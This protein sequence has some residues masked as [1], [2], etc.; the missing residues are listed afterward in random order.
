M[1]VAGPN[2]P[3]QVQF[4]LPSRDAVEEFQSLGLSMDHGVTD[5]AD[6]GALVSAWV[7][8]EELAAVRARGFDPV[9]TIADKNLIDH[10]R[11][12]RNATLEAQ[13]SAERALR[14][15][16]AG[17]RGASA[18]AGT[19][20][21]QRAEFY[22]NNVGR[23]LSIEAVA[24]SYVT[25]TSGGCTTQPIVAEWYDAAGNRIG[26]GNLIV[27]A[28]PQ[29]NPDYYQFHYQIFRIGNKGDGG[30]VP[31]S[32]KVAAPNGDVD[33][34]ATRE[35]IAE[36]PPKPPA[37]FLSGFVTHYNDSQEAYKKMRDLA[38]EFPNIAEAIN[39]PEKTL[40]YQRKAQTMLGYN[41]AAPYVTFDANN[42][43]VAGANPQ[44]AANQARTV[45]LTS[46]AH[47]HLGGNDLNAQLVNPGAPNAALSISLNGNA[48]R[49][50]LATDSGGAI[51]STAAQVVA[52]L[53]AHPQ[54]SA[55][56]TASIYRTSPANGVVVAGPVSPLSDLLR[57][58]ATFPRGPQTQTMLRIGKDRGGTKVGVFLYCQEH[59]NEIATSGVCLE[60]AER[61]VRNYGTDPETTAFV[62]GLDIFIVPQ[63][64]GDG[65]AHSIYDAN[66]RQ[67]MSNHCEDTVRFPQNEI[68]PA[69]RNGWGVDL[70]RNFSQGSVFDGY[71][72]A[73]STDCAD[74][75]F[76][77]IF[78]FSEPETRNESWVQTNY[79]NIKFINNIHSSGGFFMWP[80][81]AY[82]PVSREPLPYPP[83]G[84]LNY[85]DQTGKEV[86]DRIKSHRGTA[87]VPQQTGPVID[88]LYSAAGNSADE[89]YYSNG[90][91]GYDF[92]IGAQHFNDTGSGPATCNPGQQPVFG[93]HPTNPC[94]HNE[95]FHEAMEFA[96]G[97][98]GLLEE[99]LEY[100][101]DMTAPVVEV[102]SNPPAGALVNTYEVRF[103]SDEAASIYYT[104]DGSTPTTASTEWKPNRARG[105]PFALE[106]PAG[107]TLK[108]VA[109][110]FKGN[111]SGVRSQEFLPHVDD[112][113]D[114]SGTVPATLSLMVGPAASLGSFTPGVARTYTTSL[115][116]NVTST[117]GEATL[118]VA[119]P[120]ATAPGHLVNGAF[121]LAQPL[122]ARV[123]P[124]AL[125]NIGSAPLHLRSWSAPV[126]NDALAVDFSQAVGANDPLRTGTYSKTLTFTLS[127]TSP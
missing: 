39:L 112:E 31:A 26:G 120:S 70:N 117:A 22:S 119:D 57:A 48:I 3:A 38:D 36:D 32:V 100:A 11:T 78:E 5:T 126:S 50:S 75:N 27:S 14:V 104:T 24:E 96:S 90:I 84:T 105:L 97:N 83:Y 88:V 60:T 91:I 116:A 92:E 87:I 1:A 34:L 40:G 28:D 52:A 103:K 10:I 122:Q 64:N 76:A 23:W 94:L 72:G 4:K 33:T 123:A 77:G 7:T 46:K 89:A 80:P 73:T 17:R 29:L 55:L 53:N 41:A 79:R 107:T 121:V 19:I 71:F 66:R 63:I 109:H 15:N 65:A 124:A 111:M 44:G 30:P 8:D 101:N 102:E 110:D 56:V 98:Y 127:T 25:C 69:A 42:L 106:L 47:G 68:D 82:R 113:T 51:T 86:L 81:G 6:G 93:L 114:V 118:S 35:W 13:R 16:E 9:A 18:A 85:F 62:D 12:E 74:G 20:R 95:G 59:G 61:L 99:A 49:V 37:G 115:A 45:V 58:P 2:D 108:W 125:G 54:I 43:P 21:A 67:N